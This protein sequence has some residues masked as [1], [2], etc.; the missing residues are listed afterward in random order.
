VK[1][2]NFTRNSANKP[3]ATANN[4]STVGTVTSRTDAFQLL[5]CVSH[6]SSIAGCPNHSHPRRLHRLFQFLRRPTISHTAAGMRMHHC[7][8]Y[9]RTVEPALRQPSYP[10]RPRR[11]RDFGLSRDSP[12]ANFV[13]FALLPTSTAP[14]CLRWACNISLL[15]W[16]LFSR[17][18]AHAVVGIPAEFDDW[19]YKV[20]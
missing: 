10:N 16:Y 19:L 15:L 4:S 13:M 8:P 20:G 1:T 18:L 9:L 6:Q 14:P 5:Q 11:S 17:N 3:Y 12:P 7:Y 2:D